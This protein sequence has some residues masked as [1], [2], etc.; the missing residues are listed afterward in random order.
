MNNWILFIVTVLLVSCSQKIITDDYVQKY[1]SK[2]LL[3][4]LEKFYELNS[5]DSL[6]LFLSE[7]HALIP[8]SKAEY[9]NYN[10]TISNL[11]QIFKELYKPFKF[12]NFNADNYFENI[13]E[14]IVI[15]GDIEYAVYSDKDYQIYLAYTTDGFPNDSLRNKFKLKK[16]LGF[17]P[18]INFDSIKYLYLTSEYK[19]ALNSFL[20]TEHSELGAGDIMNTAFPKDETFNRYKFLS[21]TLPIVHGH[22][23]GYWHLETF[24][25]VYSIVLDEKFNHALIDYRVS[26]GQT[27]RN[28]KLIKIKGH[29]KLDK[30]E[31]VNMTQ[32]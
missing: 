12:G 8:S 6:M 32:E 3:D 27:V 10:D 1:T 16:L 7:W 22:W 15:Q 28:Y 17:R 9:I 5:H 30:N 23:G 2:Q 11:Y 18:I 19:E 26:I 21:P 14:Y 4:N 25:I 20:G 31:I 29:W 13:N 24:P